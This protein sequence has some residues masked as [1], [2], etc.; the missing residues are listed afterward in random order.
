MTTT[1]HLNAARELLREIRDNE[2]NA[3]DEADKFLRDGVCSE[4]SELKKQIVA[5]RDALAILLEDTTKHQ[6]GDGS[7]FFSVSQRMARAAISD[8][9]DFHVKHPHL[10]K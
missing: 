8:L 5:L 2:V 1:E 3:Q 6:C 7:R 9:A 10:T 4:L